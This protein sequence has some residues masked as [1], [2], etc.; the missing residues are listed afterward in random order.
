MTWIRS[1]LRPACM[2]SDFIEISSRIVEF[3]WCKNARTWHIFMLC[4]RLLVQSFG[5]TIYFLRDIHRCVVQDFWTRRISCMIIFSLSI[6]NAQIFIHFEWKIC[7]VKR[8]GN[9]LIVPIF[10][11]M[12]SM[13]LRD[14]RWLQENTD[15]MKEKTATINHFF[16]KILNLW[17][18]WVTIP[19]QP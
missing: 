10:P 4:Q 7:L 9:Y 17:H 12:A 6:F 13:A 19:I 8:L 16:Y 15:P 14:S 18:R 1:K 5:F 3:W 11:K 2:E